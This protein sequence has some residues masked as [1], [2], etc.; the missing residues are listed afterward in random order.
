MH[1]ADALLS[2]AVGLT[3]AA[4][5]AATVGYSAGKI[6]ED[7]DERIIPMMGVLGAFVFAA[8]MINFTIPGTGSSGHI[9]GGMLLAIVL[10]PYAAF[11]TMASILIV[12]SL[13]FADGG[14][15]ALGTNIF[16]LGLFPCFLGWFVYRALS[17]RR[18]GRARLTLSSFLAVLISL[19][20]GAFGVVVQTLL[21]G[22]SEISFGHF[23][24]L[25]LGIHLPVAAVEG[26]ITAAV[27]NFI[28]SIR[29]EL[30]KGTVT[31]SD[32][33]IK[34][35]AP[36]LVSLMGLTLLTG[37]A[38]SLFAS[39][40]PDGLEWALIRSSEEKVQE[41]SGYGLS[42]MMERFQEK[43]ALFPDYNLPGNSDGGPASGAKQPVFDPGT[44]ASG[45]IGSLAT[46]GLTGLTALVLVK[47]RKRKRLGLVGKPH[48]E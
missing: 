25:M 28:F 34:P 37:T 17:G 45:L 8:Q 6:S 39:S 22:K 30:I 23:T 20:L 14:V 7:Q 33:E 26:L 4:A 47:H 43:T 1:M 24:A 48:S 42:G 2:P 12:Q 31:N 19:Q 36:L 41:S 11:L 35:L 38:F 16:N 9:G 27:V 40:K 29:P 3:F 46:L 5:S 18:P 15:M 44:S 32:R 13:L 10:G 21:S